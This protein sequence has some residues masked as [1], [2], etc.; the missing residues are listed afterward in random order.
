MVIWPLE[1]MVAVG[2]GTPYLLNHT[3]LLSKA[4]R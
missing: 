3:L 1:V 2:M 4:N